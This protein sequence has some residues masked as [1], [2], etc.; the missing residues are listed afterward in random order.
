MLNCSSMIKKRR[1]IFVRF[2][3]FFLMFLTGRLEPTSSWRNLLPGLLHLL[4]LTGDFG[5]ESQLI[6]IKL[7]PPATITLINQGGVIRA[8]PDAVNDTIITPAGECGSTHVLISWWR[9]RSLE[10]RPSAER[11]Q[12]H[13]DSTNTFIMLT[14][15]H[16]HTMSVH[17]VKQ[18]GCELRETSCSTFQLIQES[19]KEFM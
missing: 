7:R 19:F 15:T 4:R 2:N 13:C 17:T 3:V 14:H 12:R 5:C 6:L 18:L 1:R 16:T 9:R 10:P 11:R 8:R